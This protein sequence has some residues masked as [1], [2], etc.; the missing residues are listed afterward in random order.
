MSPPESICLQCGICCDGTLFSGVLLQPKD[1]LQDLKARGLPIRRLAQG[2]RFSQPCAALSGCRCRIYPG[3]PQ[4]CR[5]FECVLLKNY[6]SDQLSA[7][8]A[9]RL[10]RR[11]KRLAAKAAKTLHL[12]G[13]SGDKSS[14]R[15]RY[16]KAAARFEVEPSTAH[17]AALF[18]ELSTTMHQLNLILSQ[19]FYPAN[20]SS[21]DG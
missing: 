1:N 9:L 10:I 11:A 3:R 6:L 13:D 4:H 19:H 15:Q 18:C 16:K 14:L 17:Q 5:Q 12:L 20:E 2:S 8:A 21:V 7:S